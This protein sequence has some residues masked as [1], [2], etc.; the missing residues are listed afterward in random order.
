MALTTTT[1]SIRIAAPDA[2]AAFELERRLS[3][4]HLARVVLD[5]EWA[6]EIDHAEGSVED[7]TE[8][9]RE[10][11]REREIACA[12]LVLADHQEP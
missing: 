5:T 11:L 10:W 1:L 9:V 3:P 8:I 7:I 6:V 2:A 12:R 4:I